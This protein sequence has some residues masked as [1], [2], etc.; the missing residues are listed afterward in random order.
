MLAGPV[1]GGALLAGPITGGALLAGAVAGGAL[2]AG[3]IAGGGRYMLHHAIKQQCST[4]GCS[5]TCCTARWII[6]HYYAGL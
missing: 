1:T 3:A 2:L 4:V 6:M 5:A